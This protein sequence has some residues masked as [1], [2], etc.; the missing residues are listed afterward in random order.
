[1]VF[2]V[3]KVIWVVFGTVFYTTQLLTKASDYH[4]PAAIS[5][6]TYLVHPI[7]I[8]CSKSFFYL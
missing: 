6:F 5:I 4:M 1:V 2:I 7:F 8:A 3:V